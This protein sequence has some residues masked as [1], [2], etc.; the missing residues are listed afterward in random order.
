MKNYDTNILTFTDSDK[1]Q[2]Y[3]W[4]NI[5]LLGMGLLLFHICKNIFFSSVQKLDL[6]IIKIH[7]SVK[8]CFRNT[9]CKYIFK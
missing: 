4:L 5:N 9:I 7:F 1:N 2:I 8:L 3:S 6:P